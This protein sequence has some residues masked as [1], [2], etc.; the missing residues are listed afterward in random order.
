MGLKVMAWTVNSLSEARRVRRLG[1][2]ALCTDRPTAMRRALNGSEIAFELE[3]TGPDRRLGRVGVGEP[4]RL[5]CVL[6]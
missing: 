4:A 1:A 3:P 2:V 5:D 6:R